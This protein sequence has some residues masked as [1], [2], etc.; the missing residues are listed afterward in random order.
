MNGR[1]VS[2]AREEVSIT[3]TAIAH[4]PLNGRPE[5]TGMEVADDGSAVARI[6]DGALHLEL[7]DLATARAW[8]NAATQAVAQFTVRL[9]SSDDLGGGEAA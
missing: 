4:L 9:P 2:G 8:Q 3:G 5:F 6:D 1:I 7:G